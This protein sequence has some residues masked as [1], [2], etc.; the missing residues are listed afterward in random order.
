MIL[1]EHA[2]KGNG[3]KLIKACLSTLESVTS[4]LDIRMRL[5]VESRTRVRGTVY[6]YLGISCNAAGKLL[7]CLSCQLKSYVFWEGSERLSEDSRGR[8]CSFIFAALSFH[9][10]NQLSAVDHCGSRTQS[11]KSCCE[12]TISFKAP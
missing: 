1:S 6:H 10:L 2:L 4:W 5:A 3:E 8:Q 11:M 9:E 12:G 7:I